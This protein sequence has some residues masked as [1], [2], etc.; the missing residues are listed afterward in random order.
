[1]TKRR[2]VA[3]VIITYFRPRQALLDRCLYLLRKSPV[4]LEIILVYDGEGIPEDPRIDL[5]LKFRDVGIG[6]A[7]NRPFRFGFEHASTDYVI[8]SPPE[9]LVEPDGV[10]RMLAG[11]QP[12]HRDVPTFFALSR[13]TTE[14]L[15]DL[16]WRKDLLCLQDTPDFW[17]TWG[18]LAMR[19]VDS[20]WCNWHINFCGATRDE[21]LRFDIL[22]DTDEAGMNENWLADREAEAGTPPI[23]S[24][25]M[26]YHQWH[27]A[28]PYVLG[29]KVY[30]GEP[31]GNV[32]R[33]E[34]AA[35]PVAESVRV[36]R[37]NPKP[38]GEA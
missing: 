26:V 36:A 12:G 9:I 24:P 34:P 10:Q 4:G 14:R 16:P 18:P 38:D 1:M 15:D 32:V 6:K 37:S 21:W 22:P 28:G 7:P 5:A 25:V 35:E 11:H 19:N 17:H 23:Q 33:S 3:T 30:S 29:G 8:H 31:V 13:E 2:K 27:D 20:Q